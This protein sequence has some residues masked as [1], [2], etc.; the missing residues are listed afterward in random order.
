MWG[1]AVPTPRFIP[2]PLNWTALFNTNP[3]NENDP[4]WYVDPIGS[5]A[6]TDRTMSAAE[7]VSLGAPPAEGIFVRQFYAARNGPKVSLSWAGAANVRLQRATTL[8]SGCPPAHTMSRS[9]TASGA[10]L[11]P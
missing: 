10:A 11:A 5:I 4:D 2:G 9:P 3:Q 8:A 1:R 7:V 6:F